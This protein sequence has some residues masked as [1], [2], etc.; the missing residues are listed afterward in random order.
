MID[1]NKGFTATY[2]G[3][4]VDPESFNDTERFEILSGSIS[5]TDSGLRTSA[6]V[7]CR[8]FD[9]TKERLIRI[10]LEAKQKESGERI[11]LFTGYATSPEIQMTGNIKRYPL[12]CFSVL[13]PAEDTYLPRGWFAGQGTQGAEVVKTL[14]A[15]CKCPVEIDGESPILSQHYIA[16]DNETNLS[17][18]DKLLTAM[19]WR[20]RIQGDG[21]VQITGKATEPVALYDPVNNDSIEPEITLSNDWYNCPNCLR[22]LTDTAGVE[23]LNEDPD[24]V[25]SIQNRG[26]EVWTQE[27]SPEL[28]NNESL[29]DYAKRRLQELQSYYLKVKYNR[30]FNPTVLV[31]DMLAL[32]YPA[33][34]ISGRYYVQSQ[35]IELG[36]GAKTNEEVS[37]EYT[38]GSE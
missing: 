32:Y 12:Q 8:K 19:N 35:T 18:I 28:T 13:K 9:A 33:Q 26:R 27:T 20:L 29:E 25:L 23:V 4:F 7:E 15:P 30:R 24:S 11:P 17:M 16:E 21:S 37:N 38:N 31:G 3:S 10:Y 1:W 34:G 14:L 22:V 36:H 6:D 2:Y 5:N